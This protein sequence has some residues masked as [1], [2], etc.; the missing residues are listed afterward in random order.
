MLR[1]WKL[2]AP[3]A[4][5]AASLPF[6]KGRAASLYLV[7]HRFFGKI[8]LMRPYITAVSRGRPSV[9]HSVEQV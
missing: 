7:T 1:K 8:L 3:L 4:L 9:I 6:P 5:T 2:I